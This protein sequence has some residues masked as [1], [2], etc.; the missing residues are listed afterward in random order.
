MTNDSIVRLLVVGDEPEEVEHL[1]SLLRGA[2]YAV[3]N[4][5]VETADELAQ[6]LDR[7]WYDLVVHMVGALDITLPDTVAT[8]AGKGYVMPIIAAGDGEWTAAEAMRA[9][10]ADR[11]TPGDSEH[12]RRIMV[13]EFNNV[14]ARRRATE[15]E[16][17][18]RESEQRARALM[19][20]S[21]DAIAYIHDGMHV[22]ANDAYLERFGYDDRETLE[23]T[24]MMD[25]VDAADQAKLK[26]FLRNFAHT[27]DVEGK[28]DLSLRK[29]DG[30]PFKA[31]M[32]F[33]RAS[34][35]GEACSQ[36]IIRDPGNTEELERELNR[37][38]QRESLTGLYNRQYFMKLLREELARATAGE[39]RAALLLLEIDDFAGVRERIGF[40]DADQVLADVARVME[41]QV[42][43]DEALARIEG[44]NYALLSTNGDADACR[45]FAGQLQEAVAGRILEIGQNSISVTLS[46]GIAVI[47][48]GID[49]PNEIHTR[50][51][52]ALG[53][54]VEA[55][56][57]GLE[58]Y[59]P[60]A[61][62]MT[63]K[64]IDQRWQAEIEAVVEQGRLRLLYQP[65]VS[66][67]GDHVPRY[68]VVVDAFDAEHERIDTAQMFAAAGR[69]GLTP[70]L[71][72]HVLLAAMRQLVQARSAGNET[73]FFLPLSDSVFDDT[74]LL[75]WIRDTAQKLEL[76]PSSLVFEVDAE[77]AAVQLKQASAFATA[78][79]R[80]GCGMALRNFGRGNEP[81]QLLHHVQVD[82]LRIA[83]PLV[84]GIGDD[85]RGQETVKRITQ[86]AR[87]QGKTTLCPGVDDV[88]SLS[89]IWSLG[90]DLIQGDFLQAPAPE[91]S[92]DFS[93]VTM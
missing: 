37:L 56:P 51:E 62:E 52:R 42:G 24:P 22:L 35:E 12:L 88:T 60:K 16:T 85:A 71:D 53:R 72:R 80:L 82:Y 33:S 19:E 78:V 55:G 92:Y 23:G 74:S 38:S 27:E 25:M 3:R 59:Q 69:L 73:V 83:D 28:L 58:V 54:A 77:V 4:A 9:G 70:K 93:E 11:A 1:A 75:R 87:K 30:T 41:E 34:I 8:I 45:R 15:L 21:R 17:A 20:T 67:H 61:G 49:D 86:Q 68:S 6:T 89:V 48:G 39:S 50:A 31:E 7:R 43:T 57:G 2:G 90:S 91:L 44:A 65:V 81:F 13:R 84:A 64:E 18:Y 79:R 32:E 10:A 46:V 66:L 63:Q 76:E 40:V 14:R 5:R 36:I 26:E 47:D 29:A